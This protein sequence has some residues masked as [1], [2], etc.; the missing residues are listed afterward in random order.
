MECIYIYILGYN[1]TGVMYEY[2]LNQEV[3]IDVQ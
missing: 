1:L 3:L 2:D